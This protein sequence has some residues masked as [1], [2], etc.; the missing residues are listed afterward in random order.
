MNNSNSIIKLS[1]PLDSIIG[2]KN[3]TIE[4]IKNYFNINTVEDF[5]KI[6]PYLLVYK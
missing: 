5:I 3:Y 4:Y 1:D 6:F 2:N